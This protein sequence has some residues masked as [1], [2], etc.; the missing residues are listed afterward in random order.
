ML[1]SSAILE[2]FL[3]ESSRLQLPEQRRWDI[4]KHLHESSSWVI[5]VCQATWTL[6]APEQGRSLNFNGNEGGQRRINTSESANYEERWMSAVNQCAVGR[7]SWDR[8]SYYS[9][10]GCSNKSMEI[11]SAADS[12]FVSFLD[13]WVMPLVFFLESPSTLFLTGIYNLIWSHQT[14]FWTISIYIHIYF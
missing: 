1:I 10:W 11:P 3:P 12:I 14:L 2:K 6:A 5:P 9:Y 8:L 4:R 13:L 7:E